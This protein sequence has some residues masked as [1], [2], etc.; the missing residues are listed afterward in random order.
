MMRKSLIEK[1]VPQL[2][3]RRQA[4]LLDVNRNRVQPAVRKV[5]P[6][7]MEICLAMDK[8]HLEHPYFGSRRM[9]KYLQA[10]DFEVG[11]GRVRRLMRRMGL[12]AIYTKPRTTIRDLSHKVHPYLLRDLEITEPNQVWC[13]DI[14]YIPMGRGFAYLTAV[15]DWKSRAVLGWSLSNTLD[16]AP[17]LEALEMAHR[18]AG[19]WPEIMNSDQG[20][21]YT[22]KAWT[23][24]L[25][26]AGVKISMDGKGCWVDN[27]FIE[28]LWRSLKYE[29]IYLR[30]YQDLVELEAGIGK[31]LNFYN[32][33]RLH[34][35]LNYTT[36]WQVWLGNQPALAA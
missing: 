5:T 14:T 21:Q 31:W 28:R 10:M 15:M 32:H 19:C 34:Q 36:P 35:A 26:D 25:K 6:E 9:A 29:D 24:A 30:E 13:T 1:G 11:R 23:D 33:G 27:V 20:C 16:T 4:K 2:S 22:S 17:C 12:V 18:T 7:E 8:L 3:V